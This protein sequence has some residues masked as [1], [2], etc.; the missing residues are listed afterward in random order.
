MSVAF[1]FMHALNFDFG[2]VANVV[3][4][5]TLDVP[6]ISMYSIFPIIQYKINQAYLFNHSYLIQMDTERAKEQINPSYQPWWDENVHYKIREKWKPLVETYFNYKQ[7]P[8]EH[9]KFSIEF[10][11]R[12]IQHAFMFDDKW[13]KFPV[14]CFNPDKHLAHKAMYVYIQEE[15]NR[16]LQEH[17]D[18]KKDA[19]EAKR[20]ATAKEETESEEEQDEQQDSIALHKLKRAATK[21]KA[22]PV[23]TES[24]NSAGQQ[25]KAARKAPGN[26]TPGI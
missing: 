18:A 4:L 6:H 17:E 25:K 2:S 24:T 8:L 5:C 22:P 15:F 3:G 9:E 12:V 1:V 7:I 23:G 20:L 13:K 21:P 19:E 10:A 26:Q 14:D 11:K 16:L